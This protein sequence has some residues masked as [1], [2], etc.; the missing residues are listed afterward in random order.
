MP[1]IFKQ[2]SSNTYSYNI[3][4]KFY[5]SNVENNTSLKHVSVFKMMLKVPWNWKVL[6][7][8]I[9]SALVSHYHIRLLYQL[10][11]IHNHP[12]HR[13]FRLIMWILWY[14]YQSSFWLQARVILVHLNA[15]RI[16]KWYWVAHKIPS[17]PK[18]CL[19]DSEAR[20]DTPNHNPKLEPHTYHQCYPGPWTPW[21][22]LTAGYS[23]EDH[24]PPWRNGWSRRGGGKVQGESGA[25]LSAEGKEVLEE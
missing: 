23:H 19:G 22:L 16:I 21:A 25:P 14:L 18:I 7:S 15:H 12:A 20:K 17:G 9:K 8:F 2:F 5:L 11:I 1:F 4:F 24:Y 3:Y 13:E 6:F 10:W